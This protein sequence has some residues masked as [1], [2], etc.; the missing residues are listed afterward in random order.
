MLAARARVR[1]IWAN[2]VARVSPKP[3]HAPDLM[4][5]SSTFRFTG[6]VSTFPQLGFDRILPDVTGESCQLL[7]VTNDVV[8]RFSL[9]E[10]ARAT[11]RLVGFLGR[12]RFPRLQDIRQFVFHRGAHQHMSVI[13]HNDV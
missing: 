5:A 6:R 3:S 10:L 7:F 12:E 11:E 1:S 8:E 13:G 2:S 4:S 9:P